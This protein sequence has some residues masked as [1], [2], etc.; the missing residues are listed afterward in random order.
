M[1]RLAAVFFS[2]FALMACSSTQR[3]P[4]RSIPIAKA[5]VLPLAL[6]NDFDFRKVS[7]FYHDPR[8]PNAVRPTQDAMIAFER[9]RRIFGAVNNYDRAERYGHYFDVWWRAKRPASITV[10]LEYRQQN[11]G[12]HVQAKEFSY[13]NVKGTVETKFTVIGDEYTEE[14][15]VTSWRLL[16]IENGK[17]VGIRQS[18]LWN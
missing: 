4:P 14:G 13:T 11:I 3:E 6:D 17:I 16:L 15:K 12:S 2:G 5:T 10:R 1:I 8:D 9:A 7:L 18:F